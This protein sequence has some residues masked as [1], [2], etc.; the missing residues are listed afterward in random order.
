M[1]E[2]LEVSNPLALCSNRKEKQVLKSLRKIWVL[3]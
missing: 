3:S 1:E 2:S